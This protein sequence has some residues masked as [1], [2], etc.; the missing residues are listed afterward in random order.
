[1]KAGAAW[2]AK[3]KAGYDAAT[4]NG[5][6]AFVDGMKV[7]ASIDSGKQRAL[8]VVQKANVVSS[9]AWQ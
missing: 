3:T 5:N 2:N 9:K 1:M 7:T 8:Y 6:E 4:E